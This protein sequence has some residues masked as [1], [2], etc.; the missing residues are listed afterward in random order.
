MYSPIS[1]SCTCNNMLTRALDL[2]LTVL[3]KIV[4]MY[5]TL[6]QWKLEPWWKTSGVLCTTPLQ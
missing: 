4:D 1:R 2:Q 5:D 6:V 3:K